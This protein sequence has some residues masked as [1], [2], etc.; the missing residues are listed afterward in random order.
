MTE[1]ERESKTPQQIIK[2]LIEDHGLSQTEFGEKCG[3]SKDVVSKL[4]NSKISLSLSVAQK[5]SKEFDVSLDYLFGLSGFLNDSDCMASFPKS[6]VQVYPSYFR[7]NSE[8][9]PECFAISISEPFYNYLDI[10]RKA[11]AVPDLPDDI[12][13][14]WIERSKKELTAALQEWIERSE[15]ELITALQEKEPLD[16]TKHREFILIPAEKI[17]DEN[18]LHLKALLE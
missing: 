14:E 12:K 6:Q 1:L 2:K 7:Y 13:K 17:N 10:R 16:D 3:L 5:I 4:L 9:F 18:M 15:K 11:A 8:E